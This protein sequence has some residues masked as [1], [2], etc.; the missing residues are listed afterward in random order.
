MKRQ[1]FARS[2][3]NSQEKSFRFRL[4]QK[5]VFLKIG[6]V[7]IGMDRGVYEIKGR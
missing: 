7:G 4:S 2:L 3:T 5:K 6:F 1:T